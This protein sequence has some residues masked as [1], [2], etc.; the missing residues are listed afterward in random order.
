MIRAAVSDRGI[1][2]SSV[3]PLV[4][5]LTLI[6]TRLTRMSVEYVVKCL[7]PSFDGRSGHALSFDGPSRRSTTWANSFRDC[8][9]IYKVAATQGADGDHCRFLSPR[10]VTNRRFGGAGGRRGGCKLCAGNALFSELHN[11]A[12]NC[13]SCDLSWTERSRARAIQKC[14]ANVWGEW[15]TWHRGC[16]S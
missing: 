15:A 6:A 5:R 11:S 1:P 16:F 3:T 2:P 8:A 10:N 4:S 12:P 9:G 13:H 14:F 7:E